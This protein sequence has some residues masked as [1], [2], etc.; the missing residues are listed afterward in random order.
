MIAIVPFYARWPYEVHI[1]PKRHASALPDLDDGQRMSLA[2]AL[3]VVTS[4][5]FAAGKP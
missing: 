1:L 3:K 5:A 4:N 2:R